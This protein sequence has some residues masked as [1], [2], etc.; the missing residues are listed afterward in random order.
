[1]FIEIIKDIL[2]FCSCACLMTTPLTIGLFINEYKKKKSLSKEEYNRKKNRFKN[3]H[4][5]EK[6]LLIFIIASGIL[7]PLYMPF[8]LF[9]CGNT[10]IGSLF[11]KL[12]YTENYYVYMRTSDSSS[13][14][15]KL[16]AT[17]RRDE[18]GDDEHNFDGY[19][20]EE[21]RF[22]NGGFVTFMEK[23]QTPHPSEE[24][25]LHEEKKLQSLDGD[26]YYITLTKEKVSD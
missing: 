16:E 8:P 26:T 13:K 23:D 1:M 25:E 24:L 15:Y 12:E 21:L 20:I 10:N 7:G 17:I 22:N 2:F 5:F 6:V 14:S 3:Y 4:F 19:F 11:E 9:G 18:Y